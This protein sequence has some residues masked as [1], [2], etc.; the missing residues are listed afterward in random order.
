MSSVPFSWMWRD[1]AEVL[2]RLRPM[3]ARMAVAEKELK[4]RERRRKARRIRKLVKLAKAR[5][6]KGQSNGR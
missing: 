4:E 6:L 5:M 2:D 3:R 1:P